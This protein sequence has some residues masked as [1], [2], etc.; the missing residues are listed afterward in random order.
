MS[1]VVRSLPPGPLPGW[2]VNPALT[3]R[4]FALFRRLVSDQT[5]IALGPHRRVLLQ[6][7]LGKR[8]RALGLR[9]FTEYYQL[10]TERDPRGDEM[11]CLVN[12]ITTNRTEFFREA[13]H[14]TYLAQTWAPTISARIAETGDRS[15]RIWSAGCS[16]GEEPY[17]IAITLR[18]ALPSLPELDARI[19]AS[20]IDTEV[21]ACAA[22][23]IYPLDAVASVSPLALRRHFLRGTGTHAGS[24]RVRPE[25]RATVTIRRINLLEHPWPIRVRFDAVFCRNVLIYFDPATQQRVLDRLVEALKDDGLLILGHSESVHGVAGLRHVGQTIYRKENSRDR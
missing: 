24:V 3:D 14:F 12:A 2:P 20:D 21:L 9:T 22:A 25:I 19:L 13:H 6:A 11:V 15:I 4:E 16:S 1:A 10:L 17:T 7:R 8:L 18:D 5:G 23:G